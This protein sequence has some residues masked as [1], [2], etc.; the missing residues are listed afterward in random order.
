MNNF[1]SEDDGLV[2]LVAPAGGVTSGV[3]VLIGGALIVPKSTAAEGELFAAH[4]RGE[5]EMAKTAADVAGQLDVAYWND[6][7][8]EITTAADDG[9][10]GDYKKV[11]FFTKVAAGGDVSAAVM[12]TGLV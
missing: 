7:A 6:A 5:H 4:Y 10:G 11:G 2:N 12:L 8:S 1:L 3:P 9:S